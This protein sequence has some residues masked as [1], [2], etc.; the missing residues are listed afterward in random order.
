MPMHAHKEFASA[1]HVQPDAPPPAGK[2]LVA[3][4]NVCT[5][6]V[7]T[8]ISRNTDDPR[9]HDVARPTIIEQLFDHA[10]LHIIGVQ[11]SRVPSYH[12]VCCRL[13]S[14]RFVRYTGMDS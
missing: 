10:G 7:A 11:E 4:A 14:E 3:S 9:M 13:R 2:L 12:T 5:L 1:R 6:G 8:N